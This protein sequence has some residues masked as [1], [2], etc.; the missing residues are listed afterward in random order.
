M[1]S[2][3]EDKVIKIKDFNDFCK[4]NGY[5]S[6][7]VITSIRFEKDKAKFDSKSLADAGLLDPQFSSE[8]PSDKT[9]SKSI[10][11]FSFIDGSVFAM[12]YGK[13]NVSVGEHSHTKG[14]LRVVMFGQYTFT[15]LPDGSVTLKAGDWIYIPP[16]QKYGYTTGPEGGGGGCCYCTRPR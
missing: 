7:E 3:F 1:S 12:V 14:F 5:S 9:I 4:R 6:E 15:G 8:M 10:L 2:D 11:P 16:N 13:P